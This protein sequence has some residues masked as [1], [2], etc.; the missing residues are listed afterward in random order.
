M[1]FV[2]PAVLVG[3]GAENWAQKRGVELCDPASLVSK[4]SKK[5]WNKAQE[6]IGSLKV[7]ALDT[8]GA[9][10]VCNLPD[11]LETNFSGIH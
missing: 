6:L 9:V 10:S 11:V 8:V 2:L 3:R 5:Q 7:E 1:Q 4:G